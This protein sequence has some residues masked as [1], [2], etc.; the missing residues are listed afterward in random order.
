MGK[1][2]LLEFSDRC[3]GQGGHH[4]VSRLSQTALHVPQVHATT[5]THR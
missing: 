1:I 2:G 4:D 5:A 3:I